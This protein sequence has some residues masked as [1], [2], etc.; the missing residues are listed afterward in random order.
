MTVTRIAALLAAVLGAAVV[1]GCATGA[2]GTAAPSTAATD[3]SG[4]ATALML[5]DEDDQTEVCVAN[6]GTVSVSLS[7][8]P[9]QDWSPVQLSGTGLTEQPPASRPTNGTVAVYRA[10]GTGT[11]DLTSSRSLCPPPSPGSVACHALQ[12]FKVTVAVR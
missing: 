11:A 1:S 4:C 12:A 3:S 10:T 6:G 8:A 9:G 2:P 7:G 5:T